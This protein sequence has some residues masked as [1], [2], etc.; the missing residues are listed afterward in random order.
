MLDPK[1]MFDHK[2]MLDHK[3]MLNRK[4]IMLDHKHMLA[5]NPFLAASKDVFDRNRVLRLAY[6]GDGVFDLLLIN[7]P[8]HK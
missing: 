7:C 1:Q 2:Q 4:H 6:I 3:H 8:L 5:D